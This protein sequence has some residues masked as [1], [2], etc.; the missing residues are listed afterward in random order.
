MYMYITKW[1]NTS[2]SPVI[3]QFDLEISASAIF[4]SFLTFKS[5]DINFEGISMTFPHTEMK[6]HKLARLPAKGFLMKTRGM[7]KVEHFLW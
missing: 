4:V 7:G 1:Q 5:E 3:T 6:W 2:L